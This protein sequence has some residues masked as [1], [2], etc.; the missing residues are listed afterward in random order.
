MKNSTKQKKWVKLRH[1]AVFAVLRV[2][3]APVLWLKYGYRAKKSRMERQPCL[4]LSNHQTTMDPFFVAKSFRFPVYYMASDDLFNLKVSKLISF[5]VAPIPKSKS[6]RDLGAIKDVL[7]VLR[8]G[9]A[10][11]IFP[12][13]NRTLSG[14]QWEMTDAIAKLAKV[15]RVPVVL[16]NLHGGYGAD[17]R[18]G[19]CSRRASKFYGVVRE[20]LPQQEIAAMPTDELFRRIREA[21]DVD[22][23]VLGARF[24]SRRRAEF[25]ERALYLC[26]VC[27]GRNTIV[28]HKTRFSCTQCGTI[29]EYTETLRIAPPV[30]G[31]D[32]IYPWFEWERQEI[33]RRVLAGEC[34]A[35]A[36][37]RF[38]ESIK[39]QKKVALDGVR[40]WIDRDAL[41]IEGSER[42]RFPFSEIDAITAVGKKK[43]NFYTHG[44]I[45]QVKGGARFCAIE[46]VH[47][48]D[49]V[50]AALRAKAQS[51]PDELR[52]TAPDGAKENL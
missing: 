36:N 33:V 38:F 47:I 15:A 17:P 9:G 27:G 49:G 1:R 31:Y 20:V 25:I 43:F 7:R 11:G 39:M 41:T 16:Y 4:I 52:H 26:P 5:L 13:G 40:V 51:A 12:E 19:A 32:T 8:E 46:Y 24:S 10:V 6:M 18:W 50:R 28:S 45:Y 3:L 48:F 42:H 29:A 22:D 21:L 35:G 30:A 14:R 2:V 34:V 37:I 44:K 23:T